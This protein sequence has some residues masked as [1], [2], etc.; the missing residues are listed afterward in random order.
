MSLETAS[1]RDA[2]AA[3]QQACRQLKSVFEAVFYPTYRTR[4]VRG[5]DEPLY[6]PAASADEDHQIIY[7]RGFLNSALHEIAH[8]CVAG[9]ERRLLE[10][11]GYWYCPDG[12]SSTQQRAFEQ[13]EI[14]PQAFEQC[15]TLALGRPF[16]IS[17]DNLSGDPG[18]TRAF[19]L[20][21]HQQTRRLL[22]GQE[23]M[24][25]R[26]GQLLEA[27]CVA[28]QRPLALWREAAI[29]RLTQ[30]EQALLAAVTEP[31]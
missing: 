11:Y 5:G 24:P 10:D 21:V 4:L 31:V 19:E 23:P 17:A 9:P 28:W 14:R 26:L 7:A 25:L 22:E 6:L 18:D 13:V 27:L 16:R 15:L 20:A 2:E 29:L 3:E 30:R 8:W 1:A 12:R